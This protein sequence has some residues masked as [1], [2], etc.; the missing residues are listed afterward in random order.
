MNQFKNEGLLAKTLYVVFT[1][2]TGGLEPILKN[3]SEHLEY[4]R[5]LERKGIMFGAGPL[6]TEDGRYAT[7]EGMIIIRANTLEEARAIAEADPMHKSGAR[8]FTVRPWV[9]NEGC[10][11]IRINYSSGKFDFS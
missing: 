4:Q 9:L 6:F 5:S 7:A 10:V 8:V 3:G 11:E 1:K 2:P